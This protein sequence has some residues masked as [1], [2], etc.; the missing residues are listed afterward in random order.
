MTLQ[1]RLHRSYH[2]TFK[3]RMLATVHDLLML[4]SIQGLQHCFDLHSCI[5]AV[6]QIPDLIALPSA[7]HGSERF[8]V[9]PPGHTATLCT[10]N[11]CSTA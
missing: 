10:V 3:L 1:T 7:Q 6:Q 4:V 9:Q 11:P 5:F 2:R 8:Q